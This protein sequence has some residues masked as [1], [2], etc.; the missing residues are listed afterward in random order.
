MSFNRALQ[1][2]A[3]AKTKALPAADAA[4]EADGVDLG[5]VALGPTG[6]HIELEVAIPATASLVNAKTITLT[7]KDSADGITYAAIPELST[8]V[9]TGAGGVGAAAATRRVRLPRTTR[10]YVT[11]GAAVEDG[12]GNNT[13]VSYSYKLIF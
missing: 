9:R 12:G 6:D 8:L 3:F 7:V 2:A 10:R 4:N 1:D 13:A 5:T 11:V